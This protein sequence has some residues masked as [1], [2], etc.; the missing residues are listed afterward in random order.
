[1]NSTI[2]SATWKSGP[3]TEWDN[4]QQ[5]LK[6]G[7][8]GTYILKHLI[9]TEKCYSEVM[10]RGFR[11]SFTTEQLFSQS[12]VR[13]YG[14]T[15][16]P[17]TQKFVLVF[18]KMDSDLRRFLKANSDLDWKIKF[19]MVRNISNSIRKLHNQDH[20]HRD[21]HSGNVLVDKNKFHCVLSDFGLCESLK[22]SK[23]L[24]DIHA[25]II[26]NKIEDM[27]RDIYVNDIIQELKLVPVNRKSTKWNILRGANSE[28]GSDTEIIIIKKMEDLLR[29]VYIN[30]GITRELNVHPNDS[31]IY[32]IR[33]IFKNKPSISED[34]PTL[35]LLEEDKSISTIGLC[36]PSE[37]DGGTTTINDRLFPIMEQEE[38]NATDVCSAPSMQKEIK[39][40]SANL[41]DKLYYMLNH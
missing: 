4:E 5:E 36:S 31:A 30:N 18:H 24:T 15:R 17:H 27:L 6:R 11:T 23:S 33:K 38:S 2:H 29:D 20:I 9:D 21:L 26:M 39:R 41:T 34:T 25:G 13:C 14:L 32:K 12:Q 19:K 3:F 7:G 35:L 28:K 10:I 37:H 1:Y 22:N 16:N 8:E 40:N